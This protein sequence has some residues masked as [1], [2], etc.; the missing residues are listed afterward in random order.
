MI[1]F[2]KLFLKFYLADTPHITTAFQLGRWALGEYLNN[3]S[4]EAGSE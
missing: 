2:L 3:F 1:T 4:W